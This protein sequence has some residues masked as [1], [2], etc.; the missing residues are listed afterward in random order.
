MI[1]FLSGDQQEV[2]IK[3]GSDL[4]SP[5]ISWTSL[6]VIGSGQGWNLE[7]APAGISTWN[8]R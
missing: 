2:H 5:V 6:S 3:I 1:S 8:Q 4:K 7:L